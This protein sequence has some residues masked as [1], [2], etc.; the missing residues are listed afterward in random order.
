[1]KLQVAFLT[2]QSDRAGSAL[3]PLQE[4][5]LDA[6]PLDEPAKV[7]VNF[8]YPASTRPHRET[9]L[10]RAS[11]N[12]VTQ[13]LG[14]RRAGFRERHRTA[15]SGLIERAGRTLFLAGS[16]GLELLGQLELDAATLSRVHVFAYGPVGRRVPVCDLRVVVGRGDWISLLMAPPAVV[17]SAARVPGGHLAYLGETAVAALCR[18]YVEELSRG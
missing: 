16:C 13:T 7:R 5:F 4:R 18:T 3:S 10:L 15:V 11:W 1:V 6:L 2:G 17:R 14:A 9:A 8:P 12:N